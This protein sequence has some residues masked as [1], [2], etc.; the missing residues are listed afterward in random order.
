MN[1]QVPE[2]S[3]E[4]ARRLL[5]DE[6]A[7]PEYNQPESFVQR[8]I[9]WVLEQFSE[10]LRVLPGSSALSTLMI[11]AV[12]VIAVAAA[13]FAARSRLRDS[14]LALKKSGSVFEDE[15]L[16]ASDYR[17]RAAKAAAAGDWDAV[18][19]D[20]YRALTASA[21]ER[22]LLDDTPSRTAHEVAMQLMPAFPAH[23]ES[24]RA[25][26]G[27]FDRVRYGKQHCDRQRAEAV[28][29]LDRDL[30]RARPESTWTE[31]AATSWTPV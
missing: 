14:T 21:G 15:K 28:G 16:G 6:L 12:V 2:P 24:L 22:T 8:V 5:Q 18:L 17:D 20:S 26:G 9:D 1:H 23:A 13:I 29:K 31:G 30:L 3:E 19:L 11:V 7:K 10:L 25:A 4:E 27:D